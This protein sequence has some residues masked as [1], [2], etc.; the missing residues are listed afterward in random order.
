VVLVVVV[1]VPV[2]VGA[3]LMAKAKLKVPA[4]ALAGELSVPTTFETS[5][6]DN[7]VCASPSKVR[8]S[9]PVDGDKLVVPGEMISSAELVFFT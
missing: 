3:A 2:V 6:A 8:L 7:V 4:T 5:F 1:V 9:V